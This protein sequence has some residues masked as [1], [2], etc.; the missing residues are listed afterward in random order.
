V[1]LLATSKLKHR[2][3]KNI[4]DELIKNKWL[5]YSG[6]LTKE[7]M[8]DFKWDYNPFGKT[9]VL[10]GDFKYYFDSDK[11]LQKQ[12]TKIKYYEI[13]IETLIDI[14]DNIKWRHQNIRNI[15]EWRK[16]NAGF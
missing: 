12:Q 13:L 7:Q 6:K 16:F 8:D 9:K 11:D 3:E 5:Y 2:S 10:K 4:Y 15:I 1:E 14:L